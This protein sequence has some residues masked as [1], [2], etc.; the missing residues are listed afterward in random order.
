MINEIEYSK[1]MNYNPTVAQKGSPSRWARLTRR[2]VACGAMVLAL[3]TAVAQNAVGTL[4]GTAG[5]TGFIDGAG[6]AAKFSFS[7]NS[8]QVAADGA[9]NLF[10][11]DTGN[12][13]I[14]KI[15]PAGV[16]SVFAGTPV[17]TSPNFTG[18]TPGSA[19]G[20]GTAASFNNPIGIAIDGAGNLYV[21]D[22]SNH[23]I[24]M[25]TSGGLVSTLGGVAA[26][27]G[28]IN[29][30]S[31][32]NSATV[33]RFNSPFG[34]AADRAGAGGA[35]TNVYIADSANHVIRQLVVAT[36]LVTTLAG[37]PTSSPGPGTVDGTD[38]TARFNHPDALVSDAPGTTLYVADTS[39]HRIR[40][41]QIAAGVATVST[42]AGPGPATAATPGSADG[43]GTAATFNNPMGIAADTSGNLYVA[44]YS[45]HTIRLINSAATVSVYAG[46][47]GQFTPFANGLA[48]AS[49]FSFPSGVAFVTGINPSIYVSDAGNNVIRKIAAAAAPVITAQPADVPAATI[50]TPSVPA[51]VTFT[52]AATGNPV[53]TYQWQRKPAQPANQGFSNLIEDANNYVGTTTPV[54][55]VKNPQAIM[56]GDQFQVVVT[57]TTTQ[58]NSVTSNVATLTVLSPPVF[59][60]GGTGGANYVFGGSGNTIPLNLT[61][62]A[63]MTITLGAGAPTFLN[64]VTGPNG[65]PPYQLT[66]VPLPTGPA[67]NY[68]FT[69][70]A[71]NGV[72]PTATQ[73]FTL[74]ATAAPQFTTQ[75]TSTPPS[76]P[77]QVGASTSFSVAATSTTGSVTYKW[78][79]APANSGSFFQDITDNGIYL[80]SSFSILTIQSVNST[81]N[82]DQFR[83]VATNING[84]TVSDVA[85]LTVGSAPAF[86]SLPT[87]TFGVGQSSVTNS[88]TVQATG[89]PTPTFT[90]TSG[91]FPFGTGAT[92]TNNNNG[93]ATIQWNMPTANDVFGSPYQ[94]VITAT[95]GSTTATQP[96]SLLVTA[97]GASPAFSTQPVNAA[98]SLGQPAFFTV[99][100]TGSPAPT[101][102][103]QRLPL[104]GSAFVNVVDDGNY[105]GSTSATL[106]ILN[107]TTA[108][109]GDTYQVVASNVV[110]SLP[111]SATS[112]TATLTVNIGTIITTFAGVTG[113][114]ATVDG[115]GL[116]AQFT[117]P[118]SI[119]VDPAGNFYVADP[120]AHVIRKITA[121]GVVSTFAGTAGS[122]GTTDGLGALARFNGPSGV[123]V[124]A[125]G[126]VYV[127]D[128][129]NHAIRGISAAGNVFTLAGVAGAPGANDSGS[130][131]PPHFTYPFGI[132]VDSSGS[133]Y[134]SDTFN[135]V[136]RRVAPNG[137]VSTVAGTAGVP[138]NT[139]GTGASARFKYPIGLAVDAAGVIYVADASNALIRRI[140]GTVVTTYAGTPGSFGTADGAALTL[141]RFNQPNGIAVDSTGV[142][143]VADTFSHTI[144]RITPST[145][146]PGTADTVV[147]I[148]GLANSPGST[149]GTG[150]TARFN[151]PNGITV[152]STGNLYIADSQNRTIRRSG[153]VT[154]AIITTQPVNASVAPGGTA[155]FT[156]VA[157]G[158]PLPTIYQWQRKP[159]DASTDFVNLVN[160]GTYGGVTTATLTVANVAVTMN[161]DVFRVRVS[162]F[163]TPDPFSNAVTLS[164]VVAAPVFTSVAA[165]TFKATELGAFPV[166]ATGNPAPTFSATGLPAWLSINSLT[167]VLSGTPPDTTGSPIA[168]VITANNGVPVTQNFALTIAPAISAPAILTQPIGSTVNPGS[169]VVLV[170]SVSG[171]AP[172]TYQWTKDGVPLSG[173]NSPVLTLSG[174][175]PANAGSYAVT[176]TNTANS[177]TSTA[178]TVAVNASPVIITQPQSQAVLAGGEVTFTVVA[179]GTPAPSYQWRFNNTNIDGA[180]NATLIRS[181]VQAATAGNY[182][183]QVGNG[184]GGA[185]PSSVAQLTI[186]QSG[187]PV[188]T[189]S[190]APRTLVVG[191]STILSVGVSAAPAVSSYQ[192]RKNGVP[193]NSGGNSATLALNNV[194]LGDGANYDVTVSNGVGSATSSPALVQV[195]SRSYAGAYFGSFGTQGNF[196]FYVR[197]DNT[198]VFLGFLPNFT[199]GSIRG[200]FTVTNGSFS[201][202]PTSVT[203]NVAINA[204]GS[205][206][207]S[208]G[209]LT[210]A[211]ITGSKS[212]DT[213]LGAGLAG[214]YQAGVVNTSSNAYAIV[215]A[216]GQ[217]FILVQAST[218]SDGGQGTL[219]SSNRVSIPTARGS[220]V[221]TFTP[222]SSAL[223]V[224]VTAGATSTTYTGAGE[225]AI[226]VQRL[227][228]LSSRAGVGAGDSVVIAGFVITGQ[229]SKPV[230]IRAIGPS[231]TRFGVT[232]PLTA[233]KLELYRAN[234]TTSTLIGTN[235]GWTTS[236]NT[237]TLQAAMTR[238][239]AFDL[240]TTSADSAIL[241]TLAPGGYTAVI[242]S[243]NGGTGAALAEV[244]DLS[245]AAAGQKLFNLS[246]RASTGSGDNTFT[247]GIVVSGAAPKRVLIRGVGP[248]LTNLGVAGAVAQPQLSLLTPAGVTLASNSG[249]SAS[250]DAP[251]LAAAAEQ[252]GAFKL[253]TNNDAAM[254]VS[255]APGNYT[256]QVTAANGV[257]GVA[258]IEIYELP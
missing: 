137:T 44:D 210:S 218:S 206:S 175:Q 130:G 43:T 158:S 147:T 106:N 180:T 184:V 81:M 207:G 174:L 75:P 231:L 1:V 114:S 17:G 50:S 148:A 226:A 78:Q 141:A 123:A 102:Q 89:S 91:I 185:T 197:P 64:V 229:Q 26:S 136:I 157:T 92:F 245:A 60:S 234:G 257:N 140:A 47:A 5:S 20:Q 164:T 28:Y 3:G 149:D 45:N 190:P 21:A 222:N 161:N 170:V 70:T 162:N 143:Y 62:S 187:P 107:A 167:G 243:N 68:T 198:G 35:A 248:T 163:I 104:G 58:V 203:V 37:A 205:L 138:G 225:G 79:R 71:S 31:T 230:L 32:P 108:M 128:T 242:S 209:G 40:K 73:N 87:T 10:V 25:I 131:T 181:N 199:T 29:N 125:S 133:V 235:V 183:V 14:R 153:A 27:P 224:V 169:T 55:T 59:A 113:Q 176:I 8:P 74:T 93:T 191:S 66:T 220:I 90:V 172:L 255:L 16:V 63:P 256:A 52:V 145:V 9:G 56:T 240:A 178:V 88:F 69:I 204:D 192:W 36:K 251:A 103:W 22:T 211:T 241:T 232:S 186:V 146:T 236:G 127:A 139:D 132:A 121:A 219:D 202:V 179:T 80:N 119:A 134:V 227:G 228:N 237:A 151:Q 216:A 105:S 247:A 165:A 150:S 67:Q 42:F 85:T 159:A 144:R 39:N 253:L 38:T 2:A 200:D 109:N 61:G 53:P 117:N 189:A 51:P 94:F 246:T 156:V 214:I 126:N 77:V 116:A 152:D 49:R 160:D 11:A 100:A 238:V 46:I 76:T 154:A 135:H 213:G 84:S 30:P 254:I 83:C 99:V 72:S 155:T 23:I 65:T 239:G 252:L 86:T 166:A 6:T 7:P 193:I 196:A 48:N 13:V 18:G 188:I 111:V 97:A 182:D 168:L 173:T 142:V 250:P 249:W 223:S 118:N 212:A 221:A 115:I 195:I 120:T 110:N 217:T 215:S 98:V 54:L 208:L 57:N 201:L 194:Q 95:S 129:N 19:D 96:F 112:T 244:Y 12:H 258:I 101:L 4:A 122:S 24:R 233:P 177:V 171:S 34:I 82:Q 41:I 15:T 124:D 33:A